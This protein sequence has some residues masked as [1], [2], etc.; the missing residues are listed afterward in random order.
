MQIFG[1]HKPY[2]V[3][4]FR[5]ANLIFK[6]FRPHYH[7]C[8]H[9]TALEARELG[10]KKISVLEFGVAGGNGL[11]SIEKYCNKIEKKIDIQFKI[12]GFDL[13]DKQGLPD[14]TMAEDLK[15]FWSTG[16]FKMNIEKLKKKI[17]KS[18]LILGDINNTLNDFILN[19]KNPPIGAI[20]FDLDLYTS[21]KKSLEIFNLPEEYRMPRIRCYFDDIQ[22]PTNNYNGVIKA[23]NEFNYNNSNKK[24][25][26][27]GGSTLDYKYGPWYEEFYEMHDF[28]HVDYNKKVS[29][30][31]ILTEV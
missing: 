16:D 27:F 11:M 17:R 31:I 3:A 25:T 12:F 19:Y 21:T 7:S 30:T 8:L 2:R 29:K 28:D 20:F 24:I 6:K 5:V 26:K 15:Y 9:E 23:I 14:T 1:Y 18:E 4:L 13:G 10:L 22:A